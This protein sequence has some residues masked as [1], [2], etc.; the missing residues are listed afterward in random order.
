MTKLVPKLKPKPECSLVPKEFCNV[1]IGIPKVVQ[2]NVTSVW[3]KDEGP[4]PPDET[5][6]KE[7]NNV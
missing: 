3:C 7:N 4:V 1:R 6:G 5:Y 2:K